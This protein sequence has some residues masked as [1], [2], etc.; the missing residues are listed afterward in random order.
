MEVYIVLAVFVAANLFAHYKAYKDVQ[1]LQI[2][3][4]ELFDKYVA[5]RLQLQ[6]AKQKE[7]AR[8]DKNGV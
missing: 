3:Y 7:E 6:F 1:K 2:E 8:C 5:C 4:S